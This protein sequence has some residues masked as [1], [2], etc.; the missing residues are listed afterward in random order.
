MKS[1]LRAFF[2]IE[3]KEHRLTLDVPEENRT[4]ESVKAAAINA[5]KELDGD[6]TFDYDNLSFGG[7]AGDWW[8][9]FDFN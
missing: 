6:D 7:F 8:I 5:L 4:N 3:G 1:E 9:S 2:T